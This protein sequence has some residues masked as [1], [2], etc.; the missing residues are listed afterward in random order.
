MTNRIAAIDGGMSYHLNALNDPEWSH[1]ISKR[2]YL[3]ELGEAD[4]GETDILIVTCRSRA[5]LLEQRRDQLA[6]FL[7]RGGWII[8]CGET[9][10]E[11]WLDDIRYV[12]KDLNYWWWLDPEGDLGL[13]LNAPDHPLAQAIPFDDMLWHH[14]GLFMPPDGAVSI[15][16]HKNGGSVLYDYHLPGGGQTTVMSLDPFFH[17]GSFFMPAASRFLRGFIPWLANTRLS[18]KEPSESL[19][20]HFQ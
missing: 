2:I 9:H 5:D 4:L 6:S 1:H 11:R 20:E 7:A 17:H 19:N 3:P 15:V 13:R 8:A 10:P 14:H 12:P 18:L 16:E